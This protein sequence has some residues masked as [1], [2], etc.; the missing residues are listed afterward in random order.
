MSTAAT[1]GIIST[2]QLT[3]PAFTSPSNLTVQ[4]PLSIN[5]GSNAV[6][7]AVDISILQASASQNGFISSTDWSNFNQKINEVNNI[8][9]SADASIYSYEL[10]GI[11]YLRKL[12]A[13]YGININ[14][15]VSVIFV[16]V[17]N[18]QESL[19]IACG[20]EITNL[21]VSGSTPAV[22]FRMPYNFT[23]TGLKAD[24]NTA[25][26]GSSI[27]VDIHKDGSTLL[28]TL[29][30]IDDGEKT[31]VTAAFPPVISDSSLNNNDEMTIFITQIGITTPGKGLKV[32]MSGI[33]I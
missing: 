16:S 29:L 21:S 6:L 19:L 15:D 7:S 31:S 23:L 12:T 4:S 32:T 14:H 11:S 33:K 22:T 10:N 17:A 18:L 8:D 27:N 24:V 20:D 2:R 5:G 3:S 1:G 25:P 30:S 26:V 9:V 13:G 28:S